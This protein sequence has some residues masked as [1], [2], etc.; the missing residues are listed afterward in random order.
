MLDIW[1]IHPSLQQK[2]FQPSPNRCQLQHPVSHFPD[3]GT[4]LG[5]LTTVEI[6]TIF[7]NE[8]RHES[9]KIL[10]DLKIP[11]QINLYGGVAHGFA[12]RGDLS[13]KEVKFATDRA[14]EQAIAWF[15]YWL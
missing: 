5:N 4:M 11:Y 13:V 14:F 7:T 2:N 12:L 10:A 3:N 1:P 15:K 8:K 6:D 9:E